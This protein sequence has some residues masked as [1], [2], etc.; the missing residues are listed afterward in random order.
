MTETV[1]HVRSLWMRTDTTLAFE[2]GY[3]YPGTI[4]LGE[5]TGQVDFPMVAAHDSY[6]TGSQDGTLHFGIQYWDSMVVS[7]YVVSNQVH[8]NG[9]AWVVTLSPPPQRPNQGNTTLFTLVATTRFRPT[10]KM[11][12]LPVVFTPLKL[13]LFTFLSGKYKWGQLPK[14]SSKTAF[15]IDT[16]HRDARVEP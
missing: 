3:F 1:T 13:S 15:P 8:E 7:D 16:R 14:P 5:T 4:L 11:I 9:V 2:V 10:E 6:N 12:Y